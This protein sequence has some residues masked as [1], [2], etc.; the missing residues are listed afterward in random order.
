GVQVVADERGPRDAGSGQTRL[1]A[2]ADVAVAAGRAVEHRRVHAAQDRIAGVR[3][4]G[5]VVGA[6][7]RRARGAD[8]ALADL[9]AVADVA[10]AARGAVDERRADAP[11]DR[12]AG[13]RRAEVAVVAVERG[14][15]RAGP[16]LTG[17]DAVA[18]RLVG[19][20]GAVRQRRRQAADDRVA[21]V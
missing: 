16:A 8:P 9:V 15:R 11:E 4:A 5:V 1:R 6:V 19:A 12:I 20:Q 17:L 7:E 18:D 10:V 13:I 21:G 3:G 2:V 14:A